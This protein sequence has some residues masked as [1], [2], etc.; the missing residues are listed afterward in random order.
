LFDDCNTFRK[1]IRKIKKRRDRG[2]EDKKILFISNGYGEDSI[3]A[4]ILK[5]LLKRVSSE[6]VIGFPLVGEG[7]EYSDLGIKIQTP[8]QNLPS[9]GLIPGGWVRN[10]WM[11]VRS[12]LGNLIFRQ[13]SVL[14]SLKNEINTVVAVGDTYPVLLGGM[15]TG[16]PVIFVGTA[17]SDY[18]VR[19]SRVER[20][21]FKRY[22]RMIFPRDE[23]TA[24]TLRKH[25]LEAR[26]E[27]N[28]MMDGI[29][30]T[31]ERFGVEPGVKII[32]LLPGS[33]TFAYGDL[34]VVL[35][36]ITM[37]ENEGNQPF[38]YLAALADSISLEPLEESAAKAGYS[39]I[40]ADGAEGVVGKLAKG[41][42]EV[43]LLRGR[44]GDSISLAYLVIGQAGTGNEQAVG[45]GKPVI[46]FDSDGQE[47]LGWY[48]ARQKGLLGDSLSVVKRDPR[49]IF[50]EALEIL[51]NEK[52][53][54]YMANVGI[55]R[56]GPPGGAKKM[57]DYIYD[58][59]S[60]GRQE[61]AL[62]TTN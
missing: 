8:T 51:S 61:P 53:Y 32:T 46:A 10:L 9:G 56:L 24:E 52:K 62:S 41:S 7:K 31:G 26:W 4:A 17:K 45:L 19:Y 39:L 48:R 60:A 1:A 36:A 55:R 13:I 58:F 37:L 27:G 35:E 18:F 11:D 40:R 38:A 14:K 57:A 34:P 22:C 25:G 6:A 44:F 3:A 59:V 20:E 50:D 23:L 2:M 5:S 42:T 12:G 30:V 28:A 47:K 21:V 16:R 43:I 15:F 33:R 54:D 29:P 49:S